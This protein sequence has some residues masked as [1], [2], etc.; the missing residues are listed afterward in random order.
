MA[1]AAENH[2]LPRADDLVE[3]ARIDDL[4]KDGKCMSAAIHG[5]VHGLTVIFELPSPDELRNWEFAVKRHR[6]GRLLLRSRVLYGPSRGDGPE[7]AAFGRQHAAES[8]DVNERL[9]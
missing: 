7:L 9:N 8:N 4:V 1:K 3:E 5:A 2:S 6:T